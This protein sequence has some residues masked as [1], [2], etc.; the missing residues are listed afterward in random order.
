[1]L[2]VK[3]IHLSLDESLNEGDNLRVKLC[4]KLRINDDEIK[5]MRI[6]KESV[7]ARK[8]NNI[9]I[10]YQ[11]LVSIENEDKIIN[12]N[13]ENVS[14]HFEKEEMEVVKGNKKLKHRPIIIGFGPAGMFAAYHLAKEGYRPIVFE[15]GSDVDS[16]QE[17]IDEFWKNGK[18]DLKSNVQ[19][20]EGGAGTFSDGKLTTR[21]KD[22]RVEIVL[23]T[24]VEN[25][26]PDEILY[27]NKA[28]VGTDI[29]RNVVKNI[30]GN[31]KKMGANVRFNS[32]M[33][34]IHYENGQLKS[35]EVNGDII[36]AENLI[37]CIGHSSR[38][39]YEMLI[40]KN[41]VLENKPFA[42]GFRIEH[43][44]SFIDKSQYGEFT[45]HPKLRSSEYSISARLK[46]ERGVYSFCMCPGGVVV[47]ASS[48]EERLAVNGMSYHA[49]D[50]ENSNSAI[51]ISVNESDYGKNILSGLE[52]QRS[53]ENR[54]FLI[55]GAN[56][57][58]PVQLVSDFIESKKSCS[59]KEVIPSIESGYN[60]ST[61][62][63]IYPKKM[64]DGL[65]EGLVLLNHKIKGFSEGGA[66]FTAAE[67]RTSAPVRILRNSDFESVGIKGVYPCGEGAGYAGGIVSAAVDGLKVSESIIKKYK[68]F[69]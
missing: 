36:E 12:K 23:N 35:I 10:N 56:Y 29:L 32:K 34:D 9:I 21:I 58:A 30:R 55:G 52:F 18:L 68:P 1:M 44:Q 62:E 67:T 25:G 45:D 19:F 16:R 57:K 24:L 46:D 3:N 33:T 50:K 49:R 13:I 20:G 22:E 60:L 47:N 61:V 26:A 53:C 28:H 42:M 2:L 37:L 48:E 4:K 64:E 63:G 17:R 65:R 51:V 69:D 27:R 43:K 5:R 38:D 39:T 54:A 59:L 14:L 11:V 31:I 6:L 40:S 66:V 8:K 41:F 7:D 15:M